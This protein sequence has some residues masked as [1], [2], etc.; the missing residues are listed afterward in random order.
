MIK[1]RLLRIHQHGKLLLRKGAVID[2]DERRAGWLRQ[3]GIAAPIELIVPIE[4]ISSREII[5]ETQNLIDETQPLDEPLDENA[6]ARLDTEEN[7]FRADSTPSDYL[8]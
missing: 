8:D 3:H 2:V 6:S 7:S 4:A 1:V 5:T